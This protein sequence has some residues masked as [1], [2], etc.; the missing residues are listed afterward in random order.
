MRKLFVIFVLLLLI[1]CNEKELG[2]N[3][4]YLPDY[5]A[6]EYLTGAFIYRS[7]NEDVFDE[8]IIYPDIKKINHNDKYI[9]AQQQPNKKLMVKRIKDNLELWNNYY[10][11]NKKDSLVQLVHKKI[12]LADIHNLVRNKKTEKLNVIADSIFNSEMFYKKMF[13]NKSNY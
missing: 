5:E 6:K 10:L 3:Y 1:S 12:F 11:E 8:I 2:N 9:I 4:Y 13:R 7:C